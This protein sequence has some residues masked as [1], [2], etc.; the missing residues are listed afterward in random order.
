[1]L[2]RLTAFTLLP[3]SDHA[4]PDSVRNDVVVASASVDRLQ[5]PIRKECML[6]R[7]LAKLMQTRQV[8]LER[9]R[10]RSPIL[11]KPLLLRGGGSA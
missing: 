11:V 9:Q 6:D 1:V 5:G 7:T 4:Q 2:A 3:C 10:E 8:N